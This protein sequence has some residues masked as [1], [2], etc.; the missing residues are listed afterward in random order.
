DHALGGLGGGEEGTERE[1]SANSL[2]DR[3]HVGRNLGPFVREQP[4]RAA[5]AALHPLEYEQQPLRIPHSA[6]IPE[7][8]GPGTAPAPPPLPQPVAAP[9]TRPAPCTG[10]PTMAAAAG[11][12]ARSTASRSPNSTT[13]K[14]GTGGPKPSRYLGFPAAAMVASVRPWNAPLKVMIRQRSG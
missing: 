5:H 7:P 9:R 13:A 11:P 2:G 10:S 14:P 1:S 4:A 12:I 6:Q 8:R 3:H